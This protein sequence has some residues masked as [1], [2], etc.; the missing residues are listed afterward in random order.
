M[1]VSSSSLSSFTTTA[2]VASSSSNDNMLILSPSRLVNGNTCYLASNLNN[3][4]A[5]PPPQSSEELATKKKKRFGSR[6]KKNEL[7]NDQ[8]SIPCPPKFIQTIDRSF[9]LGD[10]SF[11]TDNAA[12]NLYAF[13]VSI[14]HSSSNRIRSIAFPS[15]IMVASVV[16]ITLPM[17]KI[18]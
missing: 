16:D 1:S 8:T 12:Y 17:S 7:V 18:I 10:N 9:S 13:V 15:V 4:I 11:D 6:K 3:N 2:D 14:L 5:L